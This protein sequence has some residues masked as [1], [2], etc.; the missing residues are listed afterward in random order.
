MPKTIKCESCG[1]DAIEINPKCLC[2]KDF[3]MGQRCGADEII[4]HY[5]CLKC[6]WTSEQSKEGRQYME[7][8]CK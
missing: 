6:G 8:H 4:D 2:D 7:Y 1:E 3:C 5:K